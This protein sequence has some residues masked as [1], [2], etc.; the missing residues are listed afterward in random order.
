[1]IQKLRDSRGFSIIKLVIAIVM[2]VGGIGY[3]L[4]IVKLCKCDFKPSY[5]AEIVHGL[6]VVTG[7]GVVTGYINLGK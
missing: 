7:I 1:M 5:K 4:N 3:V 2:I 6:G